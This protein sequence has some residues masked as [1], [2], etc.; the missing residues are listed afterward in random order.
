VRYRRG[1]VGGTGVVTTSD[2]LEILRFS[3]GLPSVLDDNERAQRAAD[4]NGDGVI[5]AADAL[6]VLRIVVGL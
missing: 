3:V 4:V 6:A 1:D 2:A 5:D